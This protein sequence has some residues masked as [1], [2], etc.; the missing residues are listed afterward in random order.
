MIQWAKMKNYIIKSTS[1]RRS[2]ILQKEY[3]LSAPR[4][5][6]IHINKNYKPLTDLI[7]ISKSSVGTKNKKEYFNYVEIGS[8]NSSTGYVS[9]IYKK[10]IDISTDSVFSLRKDDIL[11]STVRTYLG[12]IGIITHNNDNLVS[13]K[14]LIVLRDL[15]DKTINRYYLFGI[16]RSSFFIEQTNLILNASMYPRMDKD[17]F[18]QLKIPLPSKNNHQEPQQIEQLV[19][20]VT[21]NII[22]KEEQIKAKNR[23]IDY[24]I[25]KELQESQR[26]E[27]SFQYAYPKISEIK[28]ESRLDTGIYERSYKKDEYT[29]LN[30]KDGHYFLDSKKVSPGVTP[31]DYHFSENRRNSNFYEWVTPKNVEN[32][33]IAYQTYIHTKSSTKSKPYSL[34]LNGIRYV[35]NGVFVDD[36][37]VIFSNQNTLVIN[38]FKNK[39]RQLFLLC[40]LTSGI[41]KKMQMVRRNFGIVPI[42]Y[43]EHLCKIPIP[44]FPKSK[45]Q[46][47]SK[48]YYN[49]IDK[50]Q[51]LILD[52]YLDQEKARNKELG[53]FQLNMEIFTL[54]EKL[55]D[56][57]DKI[58]NDT[59]VQINLE[60]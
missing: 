23:K 26:P 21:Q 32:R 47:I 58:I 7:K 33:Q 19:S 1:I 27:N 4:Y 46:E 29:V 8:I 30:Y 18:D 48:E 56:I 52:N 6:K 13:S 54:R 57:I 50:N 37:Q 3:I 22:D 38:Q 24:L 51:N 2:D 35:G 10:S 11:I 31:K 9:P 14:A 20:I 34:I 53:I 40:F 15:I 45:Q 25:E 44:N 42:L 12:G 28:K 16:L 17:S 39:E 36:E 59:P 41:A 60:Y 55:E 43:T 49:K 5:S